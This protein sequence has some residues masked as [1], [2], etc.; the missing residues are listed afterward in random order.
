MEESQ[1]V[2]KTGCSCCYSRVVI[3]GINDLATTAPWMMN[4]L[5]DPKDAYKYTCGS[6]KRIQVKCPNC[7]KVKDKYIKISRMNELNGIGCDCGDGISYP[8]K[9][10]FNILE[11]LN[12]KFIKEYSPYWSHGR[13]YDFY[14]PSLNLIIEMD[15]EFHDKDNRMNFQTQKESKMID[16]WKDKQANMYGLKVIRIDCNYGCMTANRFDYI[17]NN[18][19]V[20]ELSKIYDLSNVNW[21]K[22][23][24]FAL[25]NFV[26]Q[27]CEYYNS[28]KDKLLIKDICEELNISNTTLLS[29]LKKG[30]KFKWCDYNKNYTIATRSKLF[31][32]H[33][34]KRVLCVELN[35][36][37]ES[38]TECARQLSKR[39]NKKF[40]QGNISSVCNCKQ[41]S[42]NGFIFRYV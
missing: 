4:Y 26:K 13:F 39:F 30:N 25:K 14:I 5:V 34:K 37:F 31:Q 36:E 12:V 10:M 8:N 18:V 19:L 6:S 16:D 32:P 17:K 23:D 33:N 27:V 35:E 38:A 7:G 3:N 28:N 22:S 41:K 9:F 24:E 21:D 20:S 40:G 1:V 42:H 2:N 11:Q 29:Y 15:G